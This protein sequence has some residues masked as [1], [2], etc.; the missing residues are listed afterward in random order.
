MVESSEPPSKR[1]S[2]PAGDDRISQLPDVLLLQI[3]SLLPTKQAVVTGILAKRWRPL[4]PAVSVLDLDD[5]SS[6]ESRHGPAGFA[7]FV[8]SVLL[9]HDAPAIQRFRLRCANPN[10]SARDI[11][12]WLCHV[13]RRRVERVELSLSLSRYV[14]L[15]RRLFNCDTVSAMKLNGVFLNALASFSVRLPLLRALH[16]GDRVLFGC[17]DYVVKLL[18]GCPALE[19]LVLESTYNDACGGVVC[20]EGNFELSLKHLTRAKIGFSWK[21][22]C[23]KSMLLIFQALSHVRCL[24]LSPCTVACLKHASGIDI[25]MF[26][27]LTQLEISFGSYSWDLLANL[28]QR[29]HKLEVL[30]INKESQKYGKGQESRW[31]HPL[32]V[33]ECLLHLKTFCLRE[34]QGL[35]TELDF[36][37]YIMQNARVL[38][39]MTIYLSSSLSSEEKLQIRRH[40]SILQRNFE[41]CQIVFH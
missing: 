36:V 20:A 3:L 29:S 11:A 15:P 21:E 10:S 2:P 8:Y 27:K 12:T 14:A 18:A 9:L 6:P 37:G 25:P 7:E 24:S 4:W 38:E 22:R 5:E 34:Y 19:D 23:L 1:R 33:P 16:V 32:L 40:L 39:T 31:S 28:L 26:D 41:T 30:V 17:H 13:A 35:E